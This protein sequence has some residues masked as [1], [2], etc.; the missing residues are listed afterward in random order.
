MKVDTF[1]ANGIPAV[2]YPA[3]DAGRE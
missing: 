3:H 1:K 2:V